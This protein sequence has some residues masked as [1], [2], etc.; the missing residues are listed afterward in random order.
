MM[1][2]VVMIDEATMDEEV[3]FEG[4][5]EECQAIIEQEVAEWGTAESY[6]VDEDWMPVE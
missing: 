3:V 4:A 1:Y 5:L 6:I 2:R